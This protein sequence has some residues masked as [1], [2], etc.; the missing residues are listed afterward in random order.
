MVWRLVTATNY[1]TYN[2]R[3]DQYLVVHANIEIASMEEPTIMV[4]K[5][6]ANLFQFRCVKKAVRKNSADFKSIEFFCIKF[7]KAAMFGNLQRLVCANILEVTF[8]NV[9]YAQSCNLFVRNYN[10]FDT[11]ELPISNM[12]TKSMLVDYIILCMRVN[13]LMTGLVL[14]YYLYSMVFSTHFGHNFPVLAVLLGWNGS[15]DD[16]CVATKPTN[17]ERSKYGRT[18]YTVRPSRT[19]QCIRSACNTRIA[20]S[21]VRCAKISILMEY[22]TITI[23]QQDGGC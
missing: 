1:L 12:Q 11:V 19:Y 15:A 10:K 18:A 9:R 14:F 4:S 13:F 21:C 16:A 22:E 8:V 6:K 3:N 20:L 2:H 17:L 7:A 5:N 23:P